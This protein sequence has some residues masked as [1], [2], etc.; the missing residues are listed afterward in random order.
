MVGSI[1]PR[2]ACLVGLVVALWGGASLT[3]CAH[4]RNGVTGRITPKHFRFNTV[5][6]V[7]SRTQ[8]DGWRAVCIHARITEGDSGATDV[9][10]FEVGLP[11]R[12]GAQGD[13]PLELAQWASADIAN[14]AAHTV[15]ADARP[16]EMIAVL[17]IQFKRKYERMLKDELAGARVSECRTQG[18]ETVRFDIPMGGGR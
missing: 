11:I 8:P 4:A 3:G 17:C 14:R 2:G 16:G 10:K 15:L 9:C 6:A 5:V 12:N 7:G 1:R 18:I 13:I